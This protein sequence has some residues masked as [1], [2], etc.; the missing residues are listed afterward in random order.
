MSL[1]T[2]YYD[3]LADEYDVSDGNSNL[4]GSNY[5]LDEAKVVSIQIIATTLDAATSTIQ[6]QDSND[7]ENW[8]DI[9][10]ALITLDAGSSVNKINIFSFAGRFIRAVLTV[11]STTSG[12]I[13]VTLVAK[14]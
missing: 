1:F 9:T 2:T 8:S 12:T 11:N 14:N 7:N 4:I 6:I 13:T 10:G 5:S 3:T